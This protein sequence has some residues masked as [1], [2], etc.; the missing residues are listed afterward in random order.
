M[1][2]DVI[3]FSVFFEFRQING[4]VRFNKKTDLLV[5]TSLDDVLRDTDKIESGKSRH[6]GLSLG[7]WIFVV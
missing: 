4:V 2:G 5:I 7:L 6:G 3:F 1:D